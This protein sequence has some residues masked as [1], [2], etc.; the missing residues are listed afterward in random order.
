MLDRGMIKWQ[1]FD[2]L[3]SSKEVVNSILVQKNKINKPILSLDQ[4]EDLNQK[5]YES[6]YNQSLVIIKYF[7]D[8]NINQIKGKITTINQTTKIILINQ[9]LKLHIS[10]IL[11]IKA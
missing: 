6:Y 3:I 8:N 2:S 10:Q 4:M 7:Q 5:I 11:Q 9:S 1:P